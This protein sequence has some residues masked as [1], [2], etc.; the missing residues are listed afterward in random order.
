MLKK[1]LSLLFGW[2]AFSLASSAAAMGDWLR[3]HGRW[4]RRLQWVVILFYGVLLLVPVLLPLPDETARIF[5]HLTVFAQ[6]IF[7]GI[8]W[9]LV[10]L[11]M[12]LVGRAWCGILCP[13][14]ALSEWVSGKG[15]N[16]PIPRWMRWGGWPVVAFVGTTIYGQMISVYHYPKAV[17][18]ILGSATL[19]AIVVGYLYAR[20]KRVWCK[21][22]CPVNGVFGLLSKLAPMY[23]KVDAAAW[24]TAYHQTIR[25]QPIN[26][27]PLV[28]LRKMEG[29]SDCHMCGRCSGHRDAMTLSTRSPNH[30]IVK[31]GAQLATGWQSALLLFGLLG[32]ALGAFQWTVNPHFIEIKQIVAEWLIDRNILWPFAEN[33]PGWLLTHYPAQ[34]D[35][36]SWLD[37]SLLIGYLLGT[38]LLMGSALAL[39]L[40]LASRL[41]GPWQRQRFYHLNQALIPLAGCGVF[42][43]LSALTVKLLKNEGIPVFWANDVRFLLLTAATF[44]SLWLASGICRHYTSSRHRWL[45][46]MAAFCP[47]LALIDYS[48]ALMFW[49][50]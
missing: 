30:E 35:V 38:G 22:L 3:Q 23:F 17:L 24:R 29:A 11:S 4:I 47:A 20:E 46:A 15:R 7:W 48:W 31:L 18:L 16:R 43:G 8:G 34:R 12:L 42:L 36:F 39:I 50:W 21:Y 37:G 45:F 40:A 25:I 2:R 19:A 1:P 32:I 26:C 13:E 27:A 6:F 9:P 41:L 10:L 44:W 28:A 33:A 5:T 14:G 49:I